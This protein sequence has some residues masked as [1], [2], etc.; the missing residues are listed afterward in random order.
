MKNLRKIS[1]SEI[2]EAMDRLGHAVFRDDSKPF[3]LNLVGIRSSQEY[4]NTFNDIFVCFWWYQGALNVIRMDGTT[5]PGATYLKNTINEKGTFVLLPGQYRG[6]WKY[7]LHLGKYPALLQLGASV[8]GI[9]DNDKDA[10]IDWDSP[11]DAGFFGI[12]FHRYNANNIEH[13]KLNRASAGCQVVQNSDEF[14][15]FMQIYLKA[16]EYHGS[17]LTYTLLLET[18]LKGT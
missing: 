1:V 13:D 10:E 4:D 7:G 8:K 2:T 17:S 6:V 11:S 5:V 14:E 18:D 9:R 16:K 12:N 3:N 15:A